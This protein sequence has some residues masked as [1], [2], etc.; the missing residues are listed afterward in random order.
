MSDSF[1]FANL[2]PPTLEDFIR[3]KEESYDD[4][5]FELFCRRYKV[6]QRTRVLARSHHRRSTGLSKMTLDNWHQL[7]PAYPVYFQSVVIP[8][9]D[10]QNTVRHLFTDFGRREF[11]SVYDELVST[12]TDSASALATGLIVRWPHLGAKGSP[13]TGLVLHNMVVN[14]EVPGVR[15]VWTSSEGGVLTLEPLPVF[16]NSLD[17]RVDKGSWLNEENTFEY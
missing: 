6:S 17:S 1:D 10:K 12:K 8:N 5:L 4:Q 11:V 15:L 14:T 9:I 13:T 3:N 7:Y 16:L 2:R